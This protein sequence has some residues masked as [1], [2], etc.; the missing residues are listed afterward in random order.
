MRQVVRIQHTLFST[1]KP[2]IGVTLAGMENTTVTSEPSAPKTRKRKTKKRTMSAEKRKALSDAAKMRWAAKNV[3]GPTVIK[4]T[5]TGTGA[6][7]ALVAPPPA[8]LPPSPAVLKLQEQIVELVAQRS[9][10]RQRLS[11]A[12][13]AYLLAQSTFQAAEADVRATEQDAQYLLSLVAQL[14]NRTPAAPA[15][16]PVLQM[17]SGVMSGITSEPA[18]QPQ[19]A[20]PQKSYAMGSAD[21]LRR[22]MRGMM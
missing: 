20:Q 2:K 22:E 14:E 8:P 11:G 3:E 9:A 13:S 19:Q 4:G 5:S 17:P 21:D 1:A 15:S 12:H 16:A 18:L 6:Q 10:A 7:V